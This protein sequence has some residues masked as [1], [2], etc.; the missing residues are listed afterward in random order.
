MRS[1]V[2]E[3]CVF[4]SIAPS[5]RGRFAYHGNGLATADDRRVGAGRPM[6]T[7][8][9]SMSDYRQYPDPEPRG[10]HARAP[11]SAAGRR[12]GASRLRPSDARRAVRAPGAGA[13]GSAS[14]SGAQQG[15]RPASQSADGA[16]P[17]GAAAG[18]AR[19]A[20]AVPPSRR[21]GPPHRPATQARSG[22]ARRGAGAGGAG[23]GRGGARRRAA[24]GAWCSGSRSWCWW[25]RFGGPRGAGVQLLAGAEGLRRDSRDRVLGA[26]RHRGHV[27]WPTSR[28]T[29]TRFWPSTPTRWAGCTFRAPT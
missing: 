13:G 15:Y 25:S 23:Q 16:R 28:S 6:S 29:G 2:A 10:R 14:R 5:Y 18:P 8:K 3:L 20:A 1:A 4:A 17:A 11:R 24:R 12:A 7:R 27:A 19:R 22:S 26:Q 9:A 21:T